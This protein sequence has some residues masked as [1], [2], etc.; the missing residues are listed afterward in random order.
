MLGVALANVIR[1]IQLRSLNAL[2]GGGDFSYFL[3]IHLLIMRA[4][5]IDQICFYCFTIDWLID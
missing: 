4:I 2:A 1:S 3:L 5:L